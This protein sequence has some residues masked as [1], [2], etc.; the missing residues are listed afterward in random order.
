MKVLAWSYLDS[1]HRSEL[2]SECLTSKRLMILFKGELRLLEF[3]LHNSLHP[4]RSPSFGV[5]DGLS[6]LEWMSIYSFIFSVM[7]LFFIMWSSLSL[8][9][10]FE[11]FC[12]G[13]YDELCLGGAW[14]D[15]S[16]SQSLHL[17][18]VGEMPHKSLSQWYPRFQHL[19]P[20]EGCQSSVRGSQGLRLA[21][22]WP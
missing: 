22:G 10:L 6:A 21:E 3:L 14:L 1:Q 13:R 9:L 4:T 19:P 5:F 18:S 16:S 11:A 2:F 8:Y 15:F 12:S 17:E 7:S 20:S